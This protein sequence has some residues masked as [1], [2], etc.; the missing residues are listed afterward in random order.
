MVRR[1]EPYG[2]RVRAFLIKYDLCAGLAGRLAE[3]LFVGGLV[4]MRVAS[5]VYVRVGW[6]VWC[7]AVRAKNVNKRF[8]KQRPHAFDIYNI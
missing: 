2:I 8:T 5:C 6:G 1:F 4:N 3:L 7:G